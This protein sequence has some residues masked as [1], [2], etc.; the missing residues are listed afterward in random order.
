[1]NSYGMTKKDVINAE[2][3]SIALQ[4]L[5]NGAVIEIKG[6]AV[7]ET[8]DTETGEVRNV[9]YMVCTDGQIYG[10]VSATAIKSI[11]GIVEV[12]PDEAENGVDRLEVKV[13]KRKSNAGRE[14]IS[15]LIL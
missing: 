12:F 13:I 2:T 8:P 7:A 6:A 14:F 4:T 3:S 9:G 10:C 5:E 1:M 11:E 15:L